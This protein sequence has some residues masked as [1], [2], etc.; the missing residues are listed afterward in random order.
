MNEKKYYW[1]KLPKDFFKRH[2]IK[3]IESLPDGT[4]IVLFYLQ[5]MVESIDHDGELRFSPNIPYSDEMLASATDTDIDLVKKS[6]KV[7]KDLELVKVSEDGTIILEKVKNMVGF[8]T[9]W[10]E[11]KR[12]YREQKRQ[13]KDNVLDMSS[14]CPNGVRTIS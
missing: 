13:E 6:L 11:K 5:L 10:A 2:D 3:Y 8:E 1:L 4:Q 12:N 14:N 9:K 7:L